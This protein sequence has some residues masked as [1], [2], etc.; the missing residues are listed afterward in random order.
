MD[1]A[2]KSVLDWWDVAGVDVPTLP[3]TAKVKT[4]SK[5]K[6]TEPRQ[7]TSPKVQ[8][9]ASQKTENSSL[10]PDATPIAA[11]AKTLSELKLAIQSFDAGPLSSHARQ[12]V[13][14]RGNP[15]ADLMIIG[16]AP[17]REEDIAG[18]PFMGREGQLLDRMMA[19]IGLNEQSVYMTTV[20]NWR[21][22]QN[23]NPKTEEVETCRPF[24]NRHIELA[25]PKIIVL[26]GG[27]SLTALTGLTGVMKNRGQWQ[28]VS[29]GGR[30]IPALPL[31]HPALL[32]KQPALKKD[33]WR[34]L[35]DLRQKLLELT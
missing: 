23:R 30:D 22:P 29:I 4:Q 17:G 20:V 15:E 24:L 28:S 25:A 8:S 14:A 7:K 3:P 26:I 9:N 1:K 6:V 34:D 12:S 19:A 2:L 31:Y 11:A 13:F 5:S 10:R 16:E 35:L 27:V 32:L 18:K 33:A 21:L